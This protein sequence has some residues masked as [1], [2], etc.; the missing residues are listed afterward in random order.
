M[1]IRFYKITATKKII[2]ISFKDS[3]N[4]ICYINIKLTSLVDKFLDSLIS[5]GE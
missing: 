3:Q 4:Q 1:T 2:T 5:Q